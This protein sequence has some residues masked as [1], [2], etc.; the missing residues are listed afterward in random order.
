MIGITNCAQAEV[1]KGELR[2]DE[3]RTA[4]EYELAT[5]ARDIFDR[6][7]SESDECGVGTSVR[8]RV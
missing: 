4:D 3:K 5:V 8:R 7:G 2:D 6:L 1:V